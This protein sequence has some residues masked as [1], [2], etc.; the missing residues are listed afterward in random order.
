ML[1]K[2]LIKVFLC[3]NQWLDI[4][5]VRKDKVFKKQIKGNCS[6]KSHCYK[7][8]PNYEIHNLKEKNVVIGKSTYVN[9]PEVRST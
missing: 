7:N 6:N 5:M 9:K 1:A 8:N 4:N 2:L 3:G